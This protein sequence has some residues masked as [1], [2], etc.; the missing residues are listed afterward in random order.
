MREIYATGKARS[1]DYEK[2]G[3]KYEELMTAPRQDMGD[4]IT[5][6]FRNVDDILSDL[7]M[8]LTDENRRAV[9][10]LGYNRQEITRENLDQIKQMDGLLTDTLKELK[11]GKVLQ[12][13]REGVNPLT[14]PV[15]EL[16]EYLK[17]QE[18][19][20]Q[21]IES[22]SKF[23]YKLEK[24]K[25]ITPEERSAYIGIYRLV[26]QIEK[27]DDA[28]VGAIWQSGVG[29]TL[30][31]LLSAVRSSK[32]KHMDYSVDDHFGGVSVGIPG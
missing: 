11:P 22:Y 30:E 18:S 6:A 20:E 27:T 23:L 26:H 29:F 2:A 7:G 19:P 9:R 13:I 17:E 24:Q 8:E 15:E 5:K 3:S 25:G 4:S 12:M 1:A 28:A 32:H 31:N 14:M 21:E 16:S 10:I